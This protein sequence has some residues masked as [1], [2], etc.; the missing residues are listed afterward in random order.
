MDIYYEC[1]GNNTY[2]FYIKY[3]RDCGGVPLSTNGMVLNI[4]SPSCGITMP[5]VNMALISGPTDVSQ[6]CP[7]Q[8][9]FNSCNGSSIHPGT[10]EYIFSTTVQLTAQCNDWTIYHSRCCRNNAVT[11][12]NATNQS[13]YIEATLD[14]T[15]GQCNNSPQ[16]SNMPILYGCAGMPLC[17]NHGSTDPDIDSLSF[18][19]IIPRGGN[20]IGGTNL[21]YTSGHSLANPLMSS[22][23]VSFD[24]NTGQICLT[25]SQ[26]QQGVVAI[27]IYEWKNINGTY[28]NTSYSIREL[29]LII[30][31]NCSSVYA[32]EP[33][34]NITVNTGTLIDTMTVGVC[35]GQTI[36]FDMLVTDP[37]PMVN[38]VIT[39]NS[40]L[41]TP[42]ATVNVT[43]GNPVN[44]HYNWTTAPGDAGQYLISLSVD[45]TDCPIPRVIYKTLVIQVHEGISMDLPDSSICGN[46]IDL[47]ATITGSTYLWST[48]A[49]DSIETVNSNG[50]Y[51][52]ELSKGQCTIR[53]SMQ[54]DFYDTPTANFNSN[55]NCVQNPSSFFDLSTAQANQWLWDFG[56][57]NTSNQQNPQHVYSSSGSYSVQ[58]I[59]SNNNICQDTISKTIT[60]DAPMNPNIGP[61]VNQ[62]GGVLVLNG[63]VGANVSYLWNNGL[64]DSTL[65][66]TNSG[67]YW[68]QIEHNGCIERDSATINIFTP[69]TS[70]FS[71]QG[72]CTDT[73]IIFNDL[74]FSNISSWQWNFGDG[75][76]SSNQN[77]Q[78]AYVTA[79][80]Y[81]I[82]L[83]VTDVN[84][85][86]S[87]YSNLINID[88]AIILDL[89]ND[90]SQ[91]GG[92]IFINGFGGTGSYIWSNGINSNS[93][94]IS[95]SG[96][97]WLEVNNN[98]CIDRDSINIDIFPVP[99]ANFSWTGGCTDTLIAFSDLS[100]AGT[101]NWEW[102]FGDGNN[103]N[104]QNPTNQY[105]SNG[106]YSINLLI[107]DGNGC[108]DS[109]SYNLTIDTAVSVDLGPDTAICG[110][111]IDLNGYV[112]SG[113]D[114]LWSN[115]A[116]DSSINV[117]SSG[118]Y[119]IMVDNNGCIGMDTIDVTV[120][121][122]PQAQYNSSGNCQKDT[123][124]FF[125]LSSSNTVK[126]SWSFGD[127]SI[128]S[129]QNPEHT[130]SLPGTYLVKLDII[131][132]NGCLNNYS[133]NLVIHE[134]FEIDLGVDSNICGG[135]LLLDASVGANVNYLWSTGQTDSVILASTSGIYS[136]EINNNGCYSRDSIMIKVMNTPTAFFANSATCE[137]KSIQ[138]SDSSVSN[139]L[140]WKYNFGDGNHAYIPN[141]IHV[142]T[143]P[144]S[145]SIR[146]SIEDYNGCKDSIDK[147]INVDSSFTINIDNDTTICQ[148]T[149][150]IN[151]FGPNNAS[152]IWSDSTIGQ[153]LIADTSGRYICI[154]TRGECMEMDSIDI[155]LLEP[156]IA[157][158]LLPTDTCNNTSHLFT[159]TSLGDV[160]QWTWNISNG[161]SYT[162]QN[163][164]IP[165]DSGTYNIELIVKNPDGCKDTTTKTISILPIELE[166]G[167]DTSLCGGN[168]T[169]NAQLNYT[170]NYLWSDG[171]NNPIRTIDSTGTYAL[172]VNNLGC[173]E[174][175]T[176]HIE[177]HTPPNATYSYIGGCQNKAVSFTDQSVGNPNIWIWNFG[178][179]NIS[180]DQN[181]T[182]IYTQAG[183][184]SAILTI[185]DS[186]LC[187]SI[188]GN[189]ISIDDS[190]AL[191]MDPDTSLCQTN[192]NIT[193]HGPPNANYVWSNSATDSTIS[194]N[195]S[196]SYVVTV[197]RGACTEIDSTV[198]LFYDQP[199]AGYIFPQDSCANVIQEFF[200][201]SSSNVVEWHWSYGN[202]LI[203]SSQNLFVSLDSG[204]HH[205][206][207]IV[208]TSNGCKDTISDSINIIY[209]VID[210]DVK[211]DTS[212]YENN[213][214]DL[215]ALGGISYV[216][217][218][219]NYSLDDSYSSTPIASPEETTIYY[220]TI[221][222]E[223]GCEVTDSVLVEILDDYKLFIPSAFTPN[224][225]GKNDI[226][227][228]SGKGIKSFSLMI[229]NRFGELVF[230][231]NDANIGW[232]G[233]V[234]DQLSNIDKYAYY[235]SVEYWNYSSEIYKGSLHLWR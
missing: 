130:Y 74:S 161:N 10:E 164:N 135:T 121:I 233:Y 73:N 97:Y 126:W 86:T 70:D 216:W 49:T 48:G 5:A 155:T 196:G 120:N 53:D 137:N 8:M 99:S 38:Y 150:N 144:G 215:W 223:Y 156:T 122:L 205:I 33:V 17:F 189:I 108:Q 226:Y 30:V 6:L 169:L 96:L 128:D 152:Y 229:Y 113:V 201:N 93:T 208:S 78:H 87:S 231:S 174:R 118:L 109:V 217:D 143:N 37:N 32:G 110:G 225:D 62:C 151:A 83:D 206:I 195:N 123:I 75:G 34:D 54:L 185:I 168:I 55:A 59:S 200:D 56:D 221:T 69:P 153:T 184:F 202:G 181:P 125:D 115:G 7:S 194:I 182:N 173:I 92:S 165:L 29:Q 166:L 224:S 134:M 94:I 71:W 112:G 114:Y 176:I 140:S 46:S 142:Y 210:A 64:A 20:T 197:T 81:N 116:I 3:Y 24:Q 44:L 193:A 104:G 63:A 145:Y 50:L 2:T 234:N 68:M 1:L 60:I 107:T 163:I 190:I 172:E 66:V 222:D 88:S 98:G 47:D 76:S 177:V 41:A 111:S 22:T 141:P 158:F 136:V 146:L 167:P 89:G 36:D 179:G 15:N 232:N 227:K 42:S 180:N 192:L 211:N 58:L 18:E 228:V 212:I 85:C 105:L 157:E 175:D 80:S 51:W 101:Q 16:F 204:L 162:S 235:I 220:V 132:S 72:N 67:T 26:Q 191:Y 154:V 45:N 12:V 40:S 61:D 11:N 139:I 129:I 117:N 95:T 133:N 219:P 148:D 84:G 35:E 127:G 23:P 79:G 19:M 103:S 91:C 218:D 52:V 90:S 199:N 131:D 27:K 149:L 213:T 4:R 28:V 39:T 147:V 100:S 188:S 170:V 230:E 25:P 21:N 178:D 82:S 138:F 214:A 171:L 9:P 102:D 119:S 31:A 13:M 65:T 160:N 183:N 57:G 203:D 207:L 186:N 106:V 77:P 124:G 187:T 14:N 159:D 43:G 198:V 209:P